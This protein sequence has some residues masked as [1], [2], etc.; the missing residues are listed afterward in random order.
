MLWHVPRVIRDDFLS[1]LIMKRLL[2]KIKP[3]QLNSILKLTN[4]KQ[5]ISYSPLAH[6]VSNG[7]KLQG[8]L[9][10]EVL[11]NLQNF[12]RRQRSTASPLQ[13]NDLTPPSVLCREPVKVQPNCG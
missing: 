4:L 8:F 10:E 11:K 2:T 1:A 6:P 13:V 9:S 12:Y 3:E 5:L 7:R